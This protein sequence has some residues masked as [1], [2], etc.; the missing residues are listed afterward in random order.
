MWQ[1][2]LAEM[3]LIDLRSSDKESAAFLSFSFHTSVVAFFWPSVNEKLRI[4]LEKVGIFYYCIGEM[5]R[6]SAVSNSKHA[7][8]SREI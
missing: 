5:R 4:F 6:Q 3:S 1:T 8:N 2:N 7:I